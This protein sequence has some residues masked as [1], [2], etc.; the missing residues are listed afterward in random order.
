MLKKV[1]EDGGLLMSDIG[2]FL[3]T[4]QITKECEYC[5]TCTSSMSPS[6]ALTYDKC[7]EHDSDKCWY[8]ESCMNVCPNDAIKINDDVI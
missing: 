6:G 1:V 7:F 3:L 2:R 4:V 8:C 5:L